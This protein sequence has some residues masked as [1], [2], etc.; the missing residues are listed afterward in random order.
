[1]GDSG[2]V[3]RT[4]NRQIVRQMKIDDATLDKVAQALGIPAA[5]RRQFIAN[6][7]SIQI[8]RGARPSPGAPP[9]PGTPPPPARGR[10]RRT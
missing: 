1:M 10:R 7:E 9:S 8:Y 2:C 6:T 3:I 4:S 5:E